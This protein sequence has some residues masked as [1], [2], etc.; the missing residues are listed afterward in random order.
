MSKA[1][2]GGCACGAVSYDILGEPLLMADCQCRQCQR[3]SGTG[4][5][6]H[7]VFK[8]ASVTLHGE[9][10]CWQNRGDL[11]TVKSNAF[12]A[13]CGSPVYT[14]FPEMPDFIGVRAGS[15]DEP[16]RYR[17]QMILWTAAGHRWDPLDQTLPKFE[18]M[19][20]G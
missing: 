12:C 16:D 5:A 17:P 1:Y 7:L 19:Q 20:Q 18:R 6:S 3:E 2:T 4:H 13:V 10:S 9:V 8:G 14:T 11:G 15:L